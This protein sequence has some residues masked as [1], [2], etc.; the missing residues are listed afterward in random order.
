[1]DLPTDSTQEVVV[2]IH[3]VGAHLLQHFSVLVLE[4]NDL[5]QVRVW[6]LYVVS[7]KTKNPSRETFP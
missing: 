6:I 1:M 5:W 4:D 2:D 7:D 3:S